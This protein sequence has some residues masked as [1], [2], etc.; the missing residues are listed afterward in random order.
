MAPIS[1]KAVI[2]LKCPRCNGLSLTIR[3]SLRFSFSAT[4]A[5]RTSRFE[6]IPV[7]MADM[8]WIEHGETTMASVGYE[9]LARRQP[10]SSS[11]YQ[12]SA[13]FLT[14]A[15]VLPVSKYSVFSPDLV[16]TRWIST[17]SRLRSR[18]S[19]RNP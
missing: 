7:A 6:L 18:S 4:S 16:R 8:V 12:K 17:L 1:A 14:S 10:M 3:I 9:P 15:A 11:G 5:A 13:S 2:F 19:R